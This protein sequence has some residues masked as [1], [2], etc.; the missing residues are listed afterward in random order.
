MITLD[1]L[2]NA[3]QEEAQEARSLSFMDDG[4]ATGR[5]EGLEKAI[6]IIGNNKEEFD[7]WES[8]FKEFASL[9]YSVEDSAKLADNSFILI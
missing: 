6:E 2:I 4:Y 9:G 3:L 7:K 1:L 5:A 8:V